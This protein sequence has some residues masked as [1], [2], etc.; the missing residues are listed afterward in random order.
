MGAR[1]SYMTQGETMVD[2]DPGE[3]FERHLEQ[4]LATVEDEDLRTLLREHTDTILECSGGSERAQRSPIQEALR[5][6]TDR[7]VETA[8]EDSS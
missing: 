4:L 5:E 1:S 8:K 2:L 7:R 3:S 6:L